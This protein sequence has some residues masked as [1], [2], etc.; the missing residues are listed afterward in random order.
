MPPATVKWALNLVEKSHK[1]GGWRMVGEGWKRAAT[2]REVIKKALQAGAYT[3]PVIAASAVPFAVGAV[4][5][6]TM[7]PTA[8][9]AAT[10][11]ITGTFSG[12]STIP[13][14]AVFSLSGR[15]YVPGA[16]VFRV[17][18]RTSSGTGNG[19]FSFLPLTAF[20]DGSILNNVDT[21][22]T[23]TVIAMYGPGNYTALTTYTMPTA[24]SFTGQLASVSFTI[25]GAVPMARPAAVSG[26]P[27]G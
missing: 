7:T 15:G 18:V 9:T 20:A 2:R 27:E 12:A 21:K 19:A 3:A 1:R 11:F 5:G 14:G 16:T 26:N 8:G 22:V 4:T 17:L 13:L 10:L 6:P 24:T 25:T 23:S